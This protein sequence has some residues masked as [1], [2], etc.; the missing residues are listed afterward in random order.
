MFAQS[1]GGRPEPSRVRRACSLGRGEGRQRFCNEYFAILLGRIY[2]VGQVE[3]RC[4]V[5][6]VGRTS[7][8]VVRP[9]TAFAKQ[10]ILLSSNSREW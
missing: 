6:T 8:V 2:L 4:R 3:R 10:A 1:A 5:G 7:N 9:R